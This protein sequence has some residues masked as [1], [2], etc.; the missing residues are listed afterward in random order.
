MIYNGESL[1]AGFW[2][3][4]TRVAFISITVPVG[5]KLNCIL[6]LAFIMTKPI[7]PLRGESRAF[8]VVDKI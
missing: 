5:S 4:D 7:F 8:W 1:S 3:V 2:L 6:P